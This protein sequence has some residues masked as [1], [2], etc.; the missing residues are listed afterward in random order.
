MKLFAHR[1]VSAH[2]PENTMAA[3]ARAVELGVA[4][5]E[6]D[7]Q[8]SGDNVPVVIHDDSVDRTTNGTGATD[9]FT[10]HQLG[11]LDAGSGEGVPTLAQVLGLAA[12]KLRVNIEL[13]D[14]QAVGPVAAVVADIPG[15]DWFASS[16]DWNALAQMVRQVPGAKVYPLCVGTFDK[17]RAVLSDGVDGEDFASRDLQAAVDFAVRHGGEGVSV[18]EAGLDAADVAAIHD[19]GL[20]AWVWT[21]ND[22][23]RAAELLA[24]GVDGIC[25]DDPE[26]LRGASGAGRAGIPDGALAGVGG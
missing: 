22:S 15:L 6:L 4:G 5:I 14:G 3:F 8:L 25:T 9:E 24:L 21:V 18:W 10:A 16:A 26:L 17:F 7:V 12:G 23:T 1:G 2:L 20:Q 19:A 13:K 11:L